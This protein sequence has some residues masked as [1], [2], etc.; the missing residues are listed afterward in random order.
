MFCLLFSF[1]RTQ[2]TMNKSVKN[3]MKAC[4]EIN[5]KKIIASPI[6]LGDQII[7][8]KTE[9]IV[10]IK[11]NASCVYTEKVFQRIELKGRYNLSRLYIKLRLN[12]GN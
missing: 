1:L 2:H 11:K 8:I 7:N 4:F 12:N 5:Q 10:I 6:L 9:E 3:L